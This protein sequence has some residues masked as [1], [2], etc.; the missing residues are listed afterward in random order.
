MPGPG[1][2]TREDVLELQCHGGQAAARGV[3]ELALRQGARLADPGEFT[4][5]AYLRGRIDLVQ[6]EA[7][8]DAI[9]AETVETLRVHEA[10]LGGRLSE[11]VGRW[12]EAL[13]RVLA[14]IEAVLDFP[15]EDLGELDAGEVLAELEALG[16]AMGAK[17][18]TYAW[19][20][21][22]REGFR[23]ALVGSP[24]A[25][26]SSLFNCLA[27][28]ERAIVSPVPGTTRDA[29]EVRV[30]ACGAP[31][32]LVD[33][34]GLGAPRD[35]VEQEGVR[36][37]RRIAAEADLVVLLC[38]GKRELSELEAGEAVE[39]AA[40]GRTLAVVSKVDLGRA[41]A[42]ALDRI[43]G[44]AP[45]GV[46]SVTGEGVEELLRAFRDA[47]WGGRGAGPAAALT[48]ERHRRAVEAARGCLDAARQG[49][50][51][52][53]FPELVASELQEARRRL[54]ELLGWGTS[55]DVLEAIFGEFCIGK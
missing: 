15:E 48:R 46:S 25:G 8:L 36:R 47:A 10:L 41:P 21:V 24:N 52:G 40:A 18:D 11:E 43:F 34:A 49:L 44:A 53:L 7:V 17:L 12:Q 2:Y 1:S 55:E 30:N 33:T 16:D 14:R 5:R 42:A 31:V 50:R 6:A 23:V 13:G 54:E 35:E 51:G 45:L 28:E 22:S 3:L 32:R 29:I 37:A 4:L 20:R 19:G 27:A 26:K 38:E 39:L 9:R